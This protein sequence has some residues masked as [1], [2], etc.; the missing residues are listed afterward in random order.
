M[1][2]ELAN[3]PCRMS[4]GQL[5]FGFALAAQKNFYKLI[6]F[7][8]SSGKVDTTNSTFRAEKII[9]NICPIPVYGTDRLAL[10]HAGTI[11]NLI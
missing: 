3:S 11:P 4:F 5:L 1:M 10:P 9:M 7:R 6:L 2:E 8:E